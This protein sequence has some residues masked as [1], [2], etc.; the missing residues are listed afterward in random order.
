MKGPPRPRAASTDSGSP[1]RTTSRHP[2]SLLLVAAALVAAGLAAVP[3]SPAPAV[4]VTRPVVAQLA[5]PAGPTTGGQFVTLHGSGFTRAYQVT[6]GTTRTR[7]LHVWSDRELTVRAPAHG[8]GTVDVRVAVPGLASSP[9]ASARYEYVA[10]PRPLAVTGTAT[11]A[12]VEVAPTRPRPRT[13]DLSCVSATFCMAVGPEGASTYDGTSWGAVHPF[14]PGAAVNGSE[15]AC[16]ST[17]FCMA[18][19]ADQHLWRYDADGWTDLGDQTDDSGTIGRLS[20]GGPSLCGALRPARPATPVLY[21]SGVWDAEPRLAT[22]VPSFTCFSATRCVGVS[23]Y[24]NYRVF[25]RDVFGGEWGPLHYQWTTSGLRGSPL[26]DDVVGAIDC[27]GTSF[28]VTAGP[29]TQDDGVVKYAVRSG[30]TWSIAQS[31]PTRGSYPL[32]LRGTSIECADATFCLKGDFLADNEER[33]TQDWT[34]VRSTAL[35]TTGSSGATGTHGLSALSCWAPYQ[36]LGIRDGTS[37][38]VT[39]G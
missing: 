25:D 9:A 28:C 5:A 7:S 21:R 12:P 20:C 24:G 14:G 39:A 26:V 34:V 35:S 8:L 31:Q 1:M 17:S 10:R 11:P 2:R 15:V 3:A 23:D 37:V 18:K 4:A 36:C 29:V 19:A 32:T 22:S 30:S 33:P 16:T 38:R 6:F 13:N 27:A